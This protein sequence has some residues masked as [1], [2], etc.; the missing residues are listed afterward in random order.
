MVIR[1]YQD[2]YVIG[3]HQLDGILVEVD[4]LS[5]TCYCSTWLFTT[6]SNL[7][8]SGT[9][10]AA[11]ATEA[12]KHQ[13]SEHERKEHERLNKTTGIKQAASNVSAETVY[14]RQKNTG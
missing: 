2:Y 5:S 11:S 7:D 1:I 3:D 13:N 14:F 12:F 8:W 10:Q 9:S 6:A 4:P